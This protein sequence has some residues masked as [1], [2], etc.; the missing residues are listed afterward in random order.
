MSLPSIDFSGFEDSAVAANLYLTLAQSTSSFHPTRTRSAFLTVVCCLLLVT[1]FSRYSQILS[2]V[3]LQMRR[4]H[5]AITQSTSG[6]IPK[7]IARILLCLNRSFFGPIL[8]YV[9]SA[10]LWN[11]T[12]TTAL[13]RRFM[14]SGKQLCWPATQVSRNGAKRFVVSND[15]SGRNESILTSFQKLEITKA[16]FCPQENNVEARIS[17]NCGFNNNG[18]PDSVLYDTQVAD[19]NHA[20][21][22]RDE[23][24]GID[25]S[26]AELSNLDLTNGHDEAEPLFSRHST[27]EDDHPYLSN[28]ILNEESAHPSA[29][30]D[31]SPSQRTSRRTERRIN[32]PVFSEEQH[33]FLHQF[34][35]GTQ[36][37]DHEETTIRPV[38]G[39]HW[40]EICPQEHQV[41]SHSP[42]LFFGNRSVRLSQPPTPAPQQKP[43][44]QDPSQSSDVH[45]PFFGHQHQ[46]AQYSMEYPYER[47]SENV[48]QRPKGWEEYN[49]W[50]YE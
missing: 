34:M 4:S 33:R 19:P 27:S 42:P 18:H 8:R 38:Q 44:L 29:N 47:V 14:H 25:K 24:S 43:A 5:L 30:L 20:P 35:G 26:L 32:I 2:A 13:G 49:Q 9:A 1:D 45:S 17:D 48:M 6:L 37:L 21:H 28:H 16:K 10:E 22:S 11:S 36:A 40:P 7:A 12:A 31:W 23:T 41:P 3:I 15:E 39:G 46:T 50:G